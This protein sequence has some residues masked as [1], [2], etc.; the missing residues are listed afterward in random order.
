MPLYEGVCRTCDWH[1]D[2]FVSL[3]DY[4][5]RGIICPE[6]GGWARR[7]IAAVPVVGPMPSKPFV[8]EHANK[9]FES[10]AEMDRWQ[11]ANPNNKIVSATDSSFQ[12]HYDA[13]RAKA[14]KRAQSRG[15]KDVDHQ[16]QTKQQEQQDRKRLAA[17]GHKP[18]SVGSA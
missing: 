16:R 11:A 10:K 1:G 2:R 12:N 13:V 9:R 6:C 5:E 7:K 18:F 4:D 3:A 17:G 15:Y 14:D 8:V